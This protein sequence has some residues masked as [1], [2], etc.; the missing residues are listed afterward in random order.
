MTERGDM[1][2]AVSRRVFLRGGVAAALG[3]T[4][5]GALACGSGSGSGSGVGSSSAA[6][7]PTVRPKPDG[8]ITWFTWSEYVDPKI[9]KAFEKQY[10][11]QVKQTFF[12][13]DEAMVQKL[14]AGLPYDLVTTNSAYVQR[15]IAGKLLQPFDFGDLKNRDQIDTYFQAP[16]YDKGK[17][18]Y[19]IPYG[20]SPAGIAYREDKVGTLAGSWNDFWDH[21]QAA[22]HIY[23]LDQIEETLGISLVRDGAG[24]NSGQPAQVQK[25]TDQLIA[26][27]P[28]LGGISSDNIGDLTG[29]NAWMLHG[30]AGSVYQGLLQAKN[31]DKYNFVLPKDGVLIGVDTLSI[32]AKAKSPGTALLFMNWIL[33]PQWSAMNTKWQGQIVGT[34]ASKPAFDELTKKFPFL[35]FDDS[36]LTTGQWKQSL[37]GQ[38]QQ[39]WN[40]Q[41]SRFKAA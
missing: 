17:Y 13:S 27:K 30:W 31:A 34:K 24:A 41:W 3:A 20:Y 36:I 14:A 8:D 29:G 19:T 4:S 37:T 11:V 23:V 35:R 38:R 33:D 5:L 9:V 21:P 15:M 12:D 2:H 40:Q 26:L 10:G 16:V 28:R 18:R 22:K 6:A 7:A 32:G 25:A 1:D 39:L